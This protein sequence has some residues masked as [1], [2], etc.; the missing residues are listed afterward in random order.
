MQINVETLHE[1][2]RID[3]L[4]AATAAGA[5][6]ALVTSI[7]GTQLVTLLLS[8]S[9]KT[10]SCF[11]TP[12]RNTTYASLTPSLPVAHWFERTTWDMFGLVPKGHP[13]L[14]RTHLHEPFTGMSA[15]LSS[16]SAAGDSHEYHFLDVEGGGIYELPVGPIHAGIIEPG[17]FRFSCSGEIIL[18][19]EIRLGYVHR[20]VEKRLA[21]LPWPNGRFVAEATASDMPVANALAHSTAIESLF[22]RQPSLYAQLLRTLALEVER[23]AM[24]ISDLGGLAGDIGFLAVS[25]SMSRLRGL[26]LRMGELLS[27]S[28]LMRTFVCPGGVSRAIKKGSLQQVAFLAKQLEAEFADVSDFLMGNQ[29]VAERMDGVGKIP[30]RLAVD[31]G[32]VGIS[33]RSCGIDYDCRSIWSHGTFPRK[34]LNVVTE[35]HGD[36]LS[37]TKVRI[38]EVEESLTLIHWLIDDSTRQAGPHCITLPDQLPS[39]RASIGI[40]ESHRGELIHTIFTDKNGS[41]KRYSIKDPSVNNWTGLAIAVRNNLVADFPLCNKSF[42]L[43]YGG[44]DV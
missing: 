39:D 33:A 1:D 29:V 21:E 16:S 6:V 10:I 43:S 24:H 3:T 23:V 38:R 12:L 37:R 2:E 15:P 20:G 42:S 4:E 26:A 5:R 44:H 14:K 35:V 17:H 22:D 41:I 11:C 13:R 40:V 18:N 19:L 9:T 32:L 25:S 7:D 36:V 8:P 30:H 34:D 27:G 28:R 31:F